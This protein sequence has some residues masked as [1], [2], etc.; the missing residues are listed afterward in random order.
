M[1][2]FCSYFR[3][4]RRIFSQARRWKKKLSKH[5]RFESLNGLPQNQGQFASLEFFIKKCRHD[6]NKL[7]VNRNT[8]LS[9]LSSEDW[10]ALK[11]LKKGSAVVV[12]P[13]LSDTSF[14]AIYDKDLTFINQN[15]VKNT[16]NNIIA[17][18]ELPATAIKLISTPRTSYS[19][20]L[21]KGV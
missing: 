14:Y 17:K 2:K 18:Q 20:F 8:K 9:N 13:Q 19:Y 1:H 7:K 11:S 21:P 10:S 15:N 5:F 16:T 12:L 6:I 4:N 3:K